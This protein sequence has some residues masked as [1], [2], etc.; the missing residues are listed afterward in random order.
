MHE[1]PAVMYLPYMP[2]GSPSCPRHLAPIHASLLPPA[3]CT[4]SSLMLILFAQAVMQW[5]GK[6]IWQ[7]S[8]K[9]KLLTL[10]SLA[11]LAKS[12]F[13]P[14]VV[15]GHG[16]CVGG[17]RARTTVSRRTAQ[18]VG[19]PTFISAEHVRSGVHGTQH[20]PCHGDM[21]AAEEDLSQSAHGTRFCLWVDTWR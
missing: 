11:V 9:R 20:T 18:G 1:Q 4:S 8:Q 12:I 19:L 21:L 16:R 14:H 3:S 5:L 10:G 17:G 6:S 13:P 2:E 15:A 7:S